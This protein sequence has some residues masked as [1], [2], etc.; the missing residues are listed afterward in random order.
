VNTINKNIKE[1]SHTNTYTYSY[2]TFYACSFPHN[3]IHTYIMYIFRVRKLQKTG[4]GI[5]RERE[6]D[7]VKREGTETVGI[8]TGRPRETDGEKKEKGTE[9]ANR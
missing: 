5:E 8:S 1:L 6:T 7:S 4:R 3:N 9:E 2:V